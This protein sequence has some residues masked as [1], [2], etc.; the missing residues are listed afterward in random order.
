MNGFIL[1]ISII[2]FSVGLSSFSLSL[3]LFSKYKNRTLL[4]Y[5]I[6][7]GLWS[8]NIFL[9]RILDI[10]QLHFWSIEENS[11]IVTS[12]LSNFSWGGFT[13]FLIVT[14]STIADRDLSKKDV[15]L[16]LIVSIFLGIPFEILSLGRGASGLLPI[17]MQIGVHIVL[18]YWVAIN[19]KRIV[20]TFTK[21]RVREMFR[22]FVNFLLFFI[23][24]LAID[25]LPVTLMRFQFGLGIYPLFYLL[26]NLI[27]LRFVSNFIYFP[28][29]DRKKPVIKSRDNIYSLTKRELQIAKLIVEG[30][31][32][33]KVSQELNIAHETVKTHMGNIYKKTNVSNKIGLI[34][35]LNRG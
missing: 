10:L 35:A 28:K 2:C 7:M 23:P 32:Y 20:T 18:L 24:V 12:I 8:L 5:T 3:F 15:F 14:I 16:S 22:G 29:L 13:I 34:D 17:Y 33:K 1:L 31:S 6:T 11:S 21:K 26:V 27:F 9:I 30:N 19:L 4:L 25:L